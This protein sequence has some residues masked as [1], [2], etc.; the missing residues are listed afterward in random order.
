MSDCFVKIHI[1]DGIVLSIN[2]DDTYMLDAMPYDNTDNSIIVHSKE[3]SYLLQC[4]SNGYIN[5][6]SLPDLLQLRKNYTYS[7]GIFTGV[8]LQ[9]CNVSTNDDFIIALF[10]KEEKLYITI[11]SAADL[12]AHSM[13][14]L[15]GD[16]CVNTTFDI[17]R[18]WVIIPKE[19]SHNVPTIIALCS[20]NNYI[21]TENQK[22]A[23]EL[24]W[25][26]SNVFKI[27]ELQT[28]DS[29]QSEVIQKPEAKGSNKAH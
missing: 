25:I 14:G 27:Q 3:D 1:E 2:T 8:K 11:R 23:N 20:H 12:T 16:S 28:Q 21:S 10:E 29:E 13:L 22:C 18:N 4:Y 6:V 19:Q 26:N 15:K 17:I 7:H 5:K 9:Y 24:L